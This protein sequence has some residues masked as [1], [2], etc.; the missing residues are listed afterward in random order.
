M[1][2]YVISYEGLTNANARFDRDLDFS[3]D[4]QLGFI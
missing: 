2:C 4:T 1:P 3:A